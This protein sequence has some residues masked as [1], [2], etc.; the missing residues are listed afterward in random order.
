MRNCTLLFKRVALLLV[1]M[2]TSGTL[3]AQIESKPVTLEMISPQST[4]AAL[5]KY[6]EFPVELSSGGVDISIPLYEISTPKHKLPIS[7]S[8]HPGGIKVSEKASWCGLGWSVQAGGVI[9]RVVRGLPDEAVNGF[10][11]Y[12][13]NRSTNLQATQE[14]YNY[15]KS[16]AE[17]QKDGQA[18][19]YF[20]TIG[21]MSGQF[22]YGN[23]GKAYPLPFSPIKIRTDL[24][25][26][27]DQGATVNQGI[28]ITAQ[29]G[30][31][32]LFEEAETAIVTIES[33][34]VSLLT[35]WYLT[36][37]LSADGSDVI[38]FSYQTHPLIYSA[39]ISE[40][41]KYNIT[42]KSSSLLHCSNIKVSLDNARKLHKISFSG[43]E[44][45]FITSNEREDLSGDKRLTAVVLRSIDGSNSKSIKQFNFQY[46]YFL[47]PN[48]PLLPCPSAITEAEKIESKK[49]LRLDAL[50]ENNNG[51]SLP[52]YVFTYSSI[53]LLSTFATAQDHWG[54]ANGETGPNSFINETYYG[55]TLDDFAILSSGKRESANSPMQGG[56]LSKVELPTGG[57]TQYLFEPH[58][59]AAE[60]QA[61]SIGRKEEAADIRGGDGVRLSK[62]DF[63][64][65]PSEAV[66]DNIPAKIYASIEKDDQPYEGS[67][68]LREAGSTQNI[69][70]FTGVRHLS[71]AEGQQTIIKYFEADITLQRGKSYVLTAS[72]E[73]VSLRASATLHYV[74][75]TR[76]KVE[77]LRTIGGVR[78]KEVFSYD[79]LQQA[80]TISRYDYALDSNPTRSSGY[81]TRGYPIAS[82]LGTEYARLTY[83]LVKSASCVTT[84]DHYV[85]LQANPI[86]HLGNGGSAVSY[87]TVTIFREEEGAVSKQGKTEHI[88]SGAAGELSPSPPLPPLVKEC[89]D[90]GR[91]L[92]EKHYQYIDGGY[93]LHKETK[94]NYNAPTTQNLVEIKGLQATY[95]SSY[96][97]DECTPYYGLTPFLYE[98]FTLKSEWLYLESVEEKLYAADG[99]AVL[100]Q[101]KVSY[102]YANPLHAQVTKVESAQS[103]GGKLITETF[104]PGDGAY[105]AG[106]YAS[107]MA[108]NRI[109]LPL[110]VRTYEQKGQDA[111][112]LTGATKTEFVDIGNGSIYPKAV[113]TTLLSAPVTG[114]IDTYL[115]ANYH[116]QSSIESFDTYGNPLTV[117]GNDNQ[118]IST[119]W[120]YNGRYPIAQV[121]NATSSQIAYTSFEEETSGHWTLSA[122]T[123]ITTD[124]RTGRKS[125]AGSLSK[126]DLTA[127]VYTLSLWA[128]G[129]AAITIPNGTLITTYAGANGWTY[130]EWKV[131]SSGSVSVQNSGN[132]LDEV[133]LYPTN[134]RM[135]TYTYDL[136]VGQTSFTDDNHVTIF[137]QYDPLGRLQFV[138]DQNLN[139]V[140]NYVYRYKGQQ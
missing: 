98:A 127:G 83:R 124:A 29:D 112:Q 48:D 110:E 4:T 44:V 119:L 87:Q 13:P 32:Y 133:R 93:K 105:T 115:S 94:S 129:S 60:V 122:T 99:I 109:A 65:I 42:T 53:P 90:C 116:K 52:P 135:V 140:K 41:R 101:N 128:K 80:S 77:G 39:G 16:F 100:S 91:L 62:S 117:T 35:S 85:L 45:E 61:G 38:T 47:S 23:D 107:L 22:E 68:Y 79:P 57:H 46:S 36:R 64:T 26:V 139:I 3:L 28:E 24:P 113:Y 5:A 31:K 17:G 66:I 136:L 7:L 82:Y 102:S 131:N 33:Q 72:S 25:I 70:I 97:I 69:V 34:T 56:M 11:S 95:K 1:S 126:S 37:I 118:K 12:D 21:G 106:V 71:P 8:Y 88:F 54:Y 51:I 74:L 15:L 59:I 63:F 111:Q 19:T 121:Q 50:V 134:S 114:N 132:L 120:G 78:I 123:A 104:Y 86:H 18:D 20:Y 49:R 130:Y 10:L 81:L 73:D 138:K 9:S 103:D 30:T 58:V 125:F 137:Y 55:S 2:F 84:K 40:Q 6:A 92:F 14:D 67:I 75:D 89:F 43:G 76:R 27:N 96:N 108:Q